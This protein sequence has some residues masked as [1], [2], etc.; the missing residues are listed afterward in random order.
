MSF[1]FSPSDLVSLLQALNNVFN[2]L[3]SEA[4][5][6]F[7]RYWTKYKHFCY[8]VRCLDDVSENQNSS[9]ILDDLRRDIHNSLESFFRTIGGFEIYLDENRDRGSFRG[10]IKKLKWSWRMGTVQNLCEDLEGLVVFATFFLLA[11]QR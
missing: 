8:V 3:K 11:D 4:V 9:P 2:L 5:K 7:R 1:G 10:A 6:G